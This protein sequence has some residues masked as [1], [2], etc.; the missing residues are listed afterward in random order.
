MLKK[1]RK[2]KVIVKKKKDRKQRRGKKEGEDEEKYSLGKASLVVFDL[3]R[4]AGKGTNTESR[5]GSPVPLKHHGGAYVY[6]KK[7][8]IPEF[9]RGSGKLNRG[10]G[11]GNEFYK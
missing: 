10:R 5:V 3:R 4:C 6:R 2:R 1:K 9:A 7:K 11:V 8:R